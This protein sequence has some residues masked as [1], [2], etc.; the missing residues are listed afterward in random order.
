MLEQSG[1]TSG[2]AGVN[3]F[4]IKIQQICDRDGIADHS[5]FLLLPSGVSGTFEGRFA[6]TTRSLSVAPGGRCA[7]R[8]SAARAI[9]QQRPRLSRP[10][11]NS[12]SLGSENTSIAT[13]AFIADLPR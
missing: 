12:R 10:Q 13:V 6:R 7:I 2:I 5:E 8:A 4:G 3:Q 11:G 1:D 9:H